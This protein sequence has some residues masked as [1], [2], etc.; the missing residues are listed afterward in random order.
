MSNIAIRANFKLV[1]YSELIVPTDSKPPDLLAS[2][3]QDAKIAIS[4]SNPDLLLETD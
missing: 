3:T 1:L 4:R 2:E